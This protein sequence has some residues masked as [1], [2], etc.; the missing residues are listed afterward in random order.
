DR[1]L[2][3]SGPLQK[4]TTTYRANSRHKLSSRHVGTPKL[5]ILAVDIWITFPYQVLYRSS[6]I[7]AKIRTI[8]S[9]CIAICGA[10]RR[11][12]GALQLPARAP[13]A[14]LRTAAPRTWLAPP[15]GGIVRPDPKKDSDHENPHSRV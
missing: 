12:F 6:A 13:I 15:H 3:A 7:A 2:C 5:A 11:A 1:S 14:R 4:S 8:T 9:R 10:S